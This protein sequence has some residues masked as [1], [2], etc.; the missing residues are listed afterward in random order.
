MP[1]DEL[2]ALE[3]Q[4]PDRFRRVVHGMARQRVA[5]LKIEGIVVLEEQM[6]QDIIAAIHRMGQPMS[7]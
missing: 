6:A 7:P 4:Q 1:L 3:I 5:S 2:K